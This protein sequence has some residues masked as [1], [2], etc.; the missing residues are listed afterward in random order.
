MLK[1]EAGFVRVAVYVNNLI[2]I[3]SLLVQSLM[4]SLQEYVSR[5]VIS[6]FAH[7]CLQIRVVKPEHLHVPSASCKWEHRFQSSEGAVLSFPCQTLILKLLPFHGVYS[8]THFLCMDILSFEDHSRRAIKGV[9]QSKPCE[10]P[11][12][13]L[14]LP[15]LLL[16]QQ[17]V[18]WNFVYLANTTE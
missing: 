13:S 4:N 11:W 3:E 17:S 15:S 8:W 2:L 5:S 12:P 16:L 9:R 18:L 7:N 14:D 10:T 1:S 6:G